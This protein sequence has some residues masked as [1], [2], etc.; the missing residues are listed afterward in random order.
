M[1]KHKKKRGHK[2][3]HGHKGQVP[4]HILEKRYHKLGRIIDARK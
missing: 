4:L 2:K 1:A 3:H